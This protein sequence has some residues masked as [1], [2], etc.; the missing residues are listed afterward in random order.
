[1]G[2]A[3]TAVVKQQRDKESQEANT[4]E[5]NLS[6]DDTNIVTDDDVLSIV[7]KNIEV[8][9]LPNFYDTTEYNVTEE[10]QSALWVKEVSR[11]V[12][13]AIGNA[14]LAFNASSSFQLADQVWHSLN[15]ISFDAEST[16]ARHN[17][18]LCNGKIMERSRLSLRFFYE[19]LRLDKEDF[20]HFVNYFTAVVARIMCQSVHGKS[21]HANILAHMARISTKLKILSTNPEENSQTSLANGRFAPSIPIPEL[22]NQRERQGN[23]SN[24]PANQSNQNN[25]AEDDPT[26]ASQFGSFL[27]NGL[28]AMST[29]D[30]RKWDGSSKKDALKAIYF[31]TSAKFHLITLEMLN[32]IVISIRGRNRLTRTSITSYEMCATV[33]NTGFE[34]FST[35]VFQ[36]HDNDFLG[37][38][39]TSCINYA[40]NIFNNLDQTLRYLSSQPS[41]TVQSN[42]ERSTSAVDDGTARFAIDGE[43]VG[44]TLSWAFSPDNPD[45]DDLLNTQTIKF[46]S[47]SEVISVLI[48]LIL[49]SPVAVQRLAASITMSIFT[50][51]D[52][53]RQKSPIKPI[54]YDTYTAFFN[55]S[56]QGYQDRHSRRRP[57]EAQSLSHS[58]VRRKTLVAAKNDN[59]FVYAGYRDNIEMSDMNPTQNQYYIMDRRRKATEKARE[60]MGTWVLEEKGVMVQCYS[61]VIGLMFLCAL[62][63]AGGIAFGASV[64]ERVPGVDPFDI[65]SYCWVLSAFLLLMAKSIRVRTWSWTDFLHGRVLCK[66]VSELSSI[67][68]IDD[69]LIIAKLLQDESVS[70]LQ[71]RG[72]YNTV[73]N[74]KSDDGFS[75]DRPLKIWTMFLSGLIMVE[76]ETSRGAAVV[77]LDLRRGTNIRMITNLGDMSLKEEEAQYIYGFKHSK[78]DQNRDPLSKNRIRLKSGQVDWMQA[79]GIYGNEDA[80]FT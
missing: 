16:M 18:E 72:P 71:T 31:L 26:M 30:S 15:I 39:D 35:L 10:V 61:Y 49:A 8:K 50:D 6:I 41:I 42:A 13:V 19:T 22:N 14:P 4:S 43:S 45:S 58:L 68:G 9:D 25:S 77:C 78:K 74:R 80:E 56:T 46:N 2:W 53:E 37:T 76:V 59:N 51:F 32:F 20:V 47:M 1:M 64:G 33:Y 7:Q 40:R 57:K 52:E 3:P 36:D 11:L 34:K 54:T 66:S 38:S 5:L 17:K 69:Q 60:Q 23:N 55:L 44:T 75:I 24:G 63:V 65:T 28:R 21:F 48:P 62:V 79:L 12:E 70:Y 73:F 67:T 27:L 29:E